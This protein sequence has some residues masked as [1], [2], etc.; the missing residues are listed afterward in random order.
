MAAR[1]TTKEIEEYL[2]LEERR[3]ALERQARQLSKQAG[4]LERKFMAHVKEHGGA[5]LFVTS[6]GFRLGI[7]FKRGSVSWKDHFTKLA[8]NDAAETLITSAPQRESLSVQ[9]LQIV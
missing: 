5:K 9:R 2:D 6:C 3:Q 8:G 7:E 4:E 1:L